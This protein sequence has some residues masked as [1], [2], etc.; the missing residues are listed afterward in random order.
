[1]INEKELLKIIDEATKEFCGD[2]VELEKAIGMLITGRKLGW[3]V[4]LL[5]HDR[6]TIQKYDK[7]LGIN[8][9]DVLPEVGV[10]AHKSIAWNAA[11]KVGN[12]WKAVKG[13]IKGI[14]STEATK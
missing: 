4:M 6:K 5:I 9:R 13:E 12:F 8:S 1:M 10:W 14:R 7:I 11:E 3:K 2:F